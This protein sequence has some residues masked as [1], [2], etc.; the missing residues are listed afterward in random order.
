[1]RAYLDHA[2]TTPLDPRVR[3]AMLPWLG[4]APANPSS[5]HRA[6]RA[7]RAAVEGAREAVA[8]AI[9]CAPLDVVFTSGGTEA[10]N[11]AVKGI[12]WAARE[13][14]RAHLITTAVEHHAVGDPCT[15]LAAHQ[16]AQLDVIAPSVDGV[17]DAEA[18]LAAVRPDTALVAVMAVNNELGSIQPI[19]ALIEPL[20]ERGVPLIVDAVQALGH[21]PVTWSGS[22]PSALALS[23]HKHHG[24]HGVGVLVIRRDVGCAPL[25][26]GGGQER[27]LRSGTLDVASIVGAGVAAGLAV[28]DL[29]AGGP[30]RLRALGHQLIDGVVDA[31][32]H[33]TVAVDATAAH[34]VHLTVPGVDTDALLT[35]LDADGIAVS[36]GSACASGA[37]T[38]SHV[39][40]AIGAPEDAG[41][42]RVSLARTTTDDDVAAAV[43][44]LRRAV[45]ELRAAGGG[46]A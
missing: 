11:A 5:G 20:A 37:R 38:T 23:A 27:D 6:G 13:H 43:D 8:A 2:A 34:I 28:D 9:G 29:A 44:V 33:P 35:R 18:V 39:L 46:F 3:E 12:F 24:P 4:A 17:V 42:V 40:T 10:D 19:D 45:T 7:A 25:T 21:V 41:V 36:A 30:E 1:M 32:V 16:G 26:H 15:W 14:G 31:G 22:G